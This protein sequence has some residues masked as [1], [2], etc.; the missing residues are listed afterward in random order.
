MG[1]TRDDIINKVFTRAVLGYDENEVDS[2]LD[3]IMVDVENAQQRLAES[4]QENEKLK[5]SINRINEDAA[6]VMASRQEIN[7][8][9]DENKKLQNEIDDLKVRIDREVSSGR[10]RAEAEI[11]AQ[12][13]VLNSKTQAEEILR[14]A[15]SQARDMVNKSESQAER[16]LQE[17]KESAN[18]IA[19]N[20]QERERQI[21][22][23]AQDRA[24]QILDVA[25][26]KAAGL[27]QQSESSVDI[28]DGGSRMPNYER[29]TRS[30]AQE[31]EWPGWLER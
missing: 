4:Y 2:F 12:N 27:L 24:K 5:A 10:N 23:R 16:I 18:K 22:D 11:E 3:D 30:K 29:D 17:A 19:Q 20:V 1:I 13:M 7:R 9:R 8:L 28:L 25:Q 14:N 21:M 15:K 31:D 6:R 26:G